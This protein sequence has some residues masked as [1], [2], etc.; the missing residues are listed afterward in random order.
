MDF[1]ATSKATA[2]EKPSGGRMLEYLFWLGLAH[3]WDAVIWKGAW[4]YKGD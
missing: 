1:G 2:L 4:G 3:T